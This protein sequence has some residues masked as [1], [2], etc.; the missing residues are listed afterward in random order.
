MAFS[1]VDVFSE[2][3]IDMLQNRRDLAAVICVDSVQVYLSTAQST[4][5]HTH[6]LTHTYI[7]K[8][9]YTHTHPH[10]HTPSHTYTDIHPCTKL[11]PS[12]SDSQSLTQGHLLIHPLMFQMSTF[13]GEADPRPALRRETEEDRI[14]ELIRVKL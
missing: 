12:K 5:P 7:L 11:S 9:T 3:G 13:G 1:R 4:C 8:H 6:T 2:L 14:H 10:T